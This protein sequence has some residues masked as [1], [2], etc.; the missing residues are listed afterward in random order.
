MI[1]I[2]V[3]SNVVPSD[4]SNVTSVP[5]FPISK[6]SSPN[7]LFVLLLKFIHLYQAYEVLDRIVFPSMDFP[8]VSNES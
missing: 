3:S 6:T 8:L 7:L 4:V 5:S 1:S 2:R